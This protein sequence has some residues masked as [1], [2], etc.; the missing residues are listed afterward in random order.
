MARRD[1]SPVVIDDFLGLY[2]RGRGVLQGFDRDAELECPPG[3][4]TLLNNTIYYERG[5]GVRPGSVVTLSA[6]AN[7]VD[8]YPFIS[9]GRYIVMNNLGAVYDTGVST[10]T[11]IVTF[12]TGDRLSLL[13]LNQTRCLLS[14]HNLDV[15]KASQFVHIW[16]PA[17][18]GSATRKMAGAAPTGTFTVAVSATNGNCEPGIHILAV[19][20][21]FNTG[22]IT[23][24]ALYQRVT[25]PS[26]TKK[27][28][29]LTAIP[30]GPTGVV[31][32][33]IFMSQVVRNDDGNNENPELFFAKRVGDNTT[34]S[35]SGTSAINLFDTQLQ[36]SADYLKDVLVEVPAGLCLGFYQGRVQV[37][38]ENANPGTVRTSMPGDYETFRASHGFLDVPKEGGTVRN[39]AEL[40][41]LFYIFKGDLTYGTQDNGQSPN[42]WVVTIVDSGLG[43]VVN[44]IARL[45]AS[46]GY[47]SDSLL[48]CTKAGVARFTGVYDE[49][50]LSY[51][52][53]DIYQLKLSQFGHNAIT[54]VQ[55]P[56]AKRIYVSNSTAVNIL[57]GD[58]QRGLN[59]NT[60]RWSEWTFYQTINCLSQSK[61]FQG[62]PH[63]FI[64]SSEGIHSFNPAADNGTDKD[65]NN[66]NHP[67]TW[68]MIT[69]PLNFGEQ[70][71]AFALC[72]IEAIKLLAQLDTLSGITMAVNGVI[73]DLKNNQ[74]TLPTISVTTRRL[75]SYI[76]QPPPLNDFGLLVQLNYDTIA[77]ESP[78]IIQ[79]LVVYGHVEALEDPA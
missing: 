32:R 13:H 27:C 26:G 45:P 2:Y 50:M 29:D 24:P 63:L 41:G 34:T 36:Q 31:A 77:A 67:I 49:T 71:D 57:Y 12:S 74:V 8:I 40:A 16:D 19:S 46:R 4:Q 79:S 59:F 72:V 43:T 69:Q 14:P 20:F 17:L 5:I 55:D 6:I 47:S 9:N 68:M 28:I 25:S 38:G 22:F 75:K 64:G 60:I 44:G 23:K 37:G 42:R 73:R 10:S 70:E 7:I 18:M 1:Q 54:I 76:S 52:V 58:Y 56:V 66:I 65:K 15:G 39:L 11:P 48:V 51:N 78:V 21:E 53:D 3:Y 33:H 30:T 61:D 62:V 35:L